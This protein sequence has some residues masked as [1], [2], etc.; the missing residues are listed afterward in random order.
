[1]KPQSKNY[2]NMYLKVLSV[3]IIL[4]RVVVS[5]RLCVIWLFQQHLECQ[6]QRTE[7]VGFNHLHDHLQNVFIVPN[8]L[9]HI[10]I[11]EDIRQNLLLL[12]NRVPFV[13][14]RGKKV[15]AI[16]AH[17]Q[18]VAQPLVPLVHPIDLRQRAHLNLQHL[19]LNLRQHILRRVLLYTLRSRQFKVLFIRSL[20]A[21]CIEKLRSTETYTSSQSVI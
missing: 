21:Q 9:R 16:A 17:F 6:R 14:V 20:L 5:P 4:V 18:P 2:M 11:V 7:Q 15:K 8:V 13:L 19:L 1:M 3:I 10:E 12:L